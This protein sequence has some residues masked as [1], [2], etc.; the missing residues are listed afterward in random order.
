MANFLWQ[1]APLYSYGLYSYGQL[2][3]GRQ[4]RYTVMAYR[5][6]ANFLWQANALP[7]LLLPGVS[8]AVSASLRLGDLENREALS[9]TVRSIFSS[10][11]T[12]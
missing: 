5:V 4:P 11:S 9:A 12:A 8:R 7:L 6:M 1:V 3:L 10:F 2:P